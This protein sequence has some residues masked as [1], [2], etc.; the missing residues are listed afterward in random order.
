MREQSSYQAVAI[1]D[2]WASLYAF[3][4]DARIDTLTDWMHASSLCLPRTQGGQVMLIGETD[5]ALAQSLMLWDSGVLAKQELKDRAATALPPVVAA[6]CIW[7]NR[8][9]VMN[10]MNEIGVLRGDYAAVEI[11]GEEVP[12][13]L[14]PVPIAPPRNI[15]ARQLEGTHDRVRAIVR[16]RVQARDEL[17]LR[18]RAS[19]AKHMATRNPKELHFKMDPKDL[20]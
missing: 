2:A 16:V 7:G 11:N 15:A 13:F 14:G 4:V 19:V 17:A 18:L 12:G 20:M 1:L 6:A 8:D 5:P 3:G 10:T 9:A